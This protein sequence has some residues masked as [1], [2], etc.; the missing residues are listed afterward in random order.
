[1][2]LTFFIIF[3]KLNALFYFSMKSGFNKWIIFVIYVIINAVLT[4]F[5]FGSDAHILF[6]VVPIVLVFEFGIASCFITRY[7]E[8]LVGLGLC[9]FL[10]L[11]YLLI[12]YVVRAIASIRLPIH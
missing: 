3:V 12:E 8:I 11:F 5:L 4:H 6:V 10:D 9:I 1:M 7:A 2:L